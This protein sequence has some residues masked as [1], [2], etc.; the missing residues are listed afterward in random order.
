[1][2]SS[3]SAAVLLPVVVYM[4][5]NLAFFGSYYKTYLSKALASPTREYK[6]PI[7]THSCLN[8]MN[9]EI[10]NLIN[11]NTYEPTIP[12]TLS[13]IYKIDPN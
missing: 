13:S 6:C 9:C 8:D 4:I 2:K 7:K 3:I 1:M 11:H 10:S 12:S 5:S